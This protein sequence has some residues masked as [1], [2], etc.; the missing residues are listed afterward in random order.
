MK[1]EIKDSF[2]KQWGIEKWNKIVDLAHDMEIFL[3]YKFRNQENLLRPFMIKKD[4]LD[5]HY[6]EII[7]FLGDSILN[8][9]VSE[10]L[11]EKF[12]L[13]KPEELTRIKSMLTKNSYLAS[14]SKALPLKDLERIF[15]DEIILTKKNYSDC[16]ESILGAMYIDMEYNKEE[17][18][19]IIL[20]LIKIEKLPINEIIITNNLKDTKSMLNEWVQ[21]EYEGNVIINY[22]YR[23]EGPD[24]KL[25]FYVGLQLKRKDGKIIFQED[26]TGPFDRLKD[27]EYSVSE[28]FL[29]KLT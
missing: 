23:T 22:P 3:H 6:F 12:K 27:G 21:K 17:I 16:V 5:N 18:K 10:Y 4:I 2:I 1:S 9:V 13:K 24:H 29:L 14:L 28:N 19:P 20:N 26:E 15:D 7:E 8:L 25:Q 11:I